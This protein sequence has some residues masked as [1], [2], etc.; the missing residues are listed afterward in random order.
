M[1][2]ER[3]VAFVPIKMNSQRLPY[4][5]I[6]PIAGR[7]MCRYIFDSLLEVNEID[8]CYV[9]CSD[10]VIQDYIPEGIRFLKRDR[11]LDADLVKGG[12]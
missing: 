2:K 9:Y 1:K 3:V 5:N 11:S 7:P 6:L 10:A 4:K 8:T 12:I